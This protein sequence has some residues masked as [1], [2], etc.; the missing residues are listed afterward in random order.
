MAE[1]L[2]NEWG[3][4]RRGGPMDTQWCDDFHDRLED[5]CRGGHVM[6]ALAH[7]LLTTHRECD[8]WFEAT[9]YPESHDEVGNEDDR[10][11]NIAGWGR[12]LRMS[13][14]AAGVTLASR[15]IPMF[16]MGLEAG[17]HRQFKMGN[18]DVPDLDEYLRDDARRRLRAWWRALC[19]LRADDNLSGP[20][21]LTVPL[22]EHQLLAI[23]RGQSADIIVVVNF[24][25]W[26]GTLRLEQVGAGD[27]AYREWLNSTWPAF[28]VE[29]EDEH[30]NGGRDARLRGGDTLR[31]PDYGV[32][33]LQRV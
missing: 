4:T 3:V 12:G 26:S 17:E 19:E 14:V 18:D 23:T 33:V 31:V 27:G 21:P 30:T 2:P 1:H 25:G 7:A 22:A 28:A 5:A 32:I 29:H 9:N 24:G 16:F 10:I 20:A 8:D 11:A 13:K 6:P 15:G